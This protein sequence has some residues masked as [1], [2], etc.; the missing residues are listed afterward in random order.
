[1]VSSKR[2][3]VILVLLSVLCSFCLATD[4]EGTSLPFPLPQGI[5]SFSM[6]YENDVVFEPTNEDRD[7]TM[8]LQFDLTGPWVARSPLGRSLHWLNG[9]A[10]V[11]RFHQ[12]NASGESF[13]LSLSNAAFTPDDLSD[14][15][16]IFNDRPYASLVLLTTTHNTR[17]GL[18]RGFS[19]RL[20]LGVL[21][22]D[23]SERAQTW[24]HQELRGEG[25][26]EPVDPK[27]WSHQISDGGEL[28]LG[29][30]L[31]HKQ[32]LVA[33]RNFD[34]QSEQELSLGYDTSLAAGGTLRLGRIRGDWWRFRHRSFAP[35]QGANQR[36]GR[37]WEAYFWAGYSLKLVAYNVLLQ[38]Q[39]RHS[40]VTFP[41]SEIERLIH[42]G[43]C[44]AVLRYGPIGINYEVSL[45]SSELKILNY[46]HLWGGCYLTWFF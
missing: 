39:F 5:T 21:G 32:L 30:R 24:I 13:E 25:Q 37:R 3:G 11:D 42:E 29:Y 43:R 10:G 18:N 31:K 14:P 22:L 20:T 12:D 2:V 1:M 15:E 19:S 26:L 44:G 16:A 46:S 8:G 6:L 27:G 23:V 36:T 38:G 7:F 9:L 34:L 17:I 28:T 35:E 45:R 41:A 4:E 33:K 40:D